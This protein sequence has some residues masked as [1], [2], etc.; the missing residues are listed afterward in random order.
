MMG[1]L[2]HVKDRYQATHRATPGFSRLGSWL[3]T[4]G[5]RRWVVGGAAALVMTLTLALVVSYASLSSAFDKIGHQSLGDLGQRPHITTAAGTSAPVTILLI[6]SDSRAGANASYGK[7]EGQRADVTM[8]LQISGDRTR[9]TA[10]SIPRDSMVDMPSCQKADG[11]WSH[12]QTQMFN[13]AFAL[14]GPTCTIRT[15]EH[16]TGVY[17]NHFVIVDFSGFKAMVDALGT[18]PICVPEDV[19]DPHKSG[20]VISA[21]RHD[22]DG[23]TA[24]AYVRNRTMGQGGDLGRVKRQQQFVAT[25]VNEATSRGV[26]TNPPTVMR[27]LKA[28]AGSLT[29]DDGMQ[30]SEM[31]SMARTLHSIGMDHITFLT[32]PVTGYAPDPNRLAWAPQAE[33]LWQAL[34]TDTP[35]PA[36]SAASSSPSSN[37]TRAMHIS[38]SNSDAPT[39]ESAPDSPRYSHLNPSTATLDACR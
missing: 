20:L 29:T 22:V 5:L 27:F 38:S 33:V 23:A 36:P 30:R 24:L 19:N 15:V 21:G 31:I 28:A 26:L 18:V 9:A 32:V 6:G 34:R 3:R 1:W 16:L 39:L 10:V 7:V 25:L 8:L 2:G 17:I 37:A 35:L 12:P 4:K 13:A 11:T 14:G